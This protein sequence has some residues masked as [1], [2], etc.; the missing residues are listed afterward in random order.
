MTLGEGVKDFA[1]QRPLRRMRVLVARYGE[2]VEE[3]VTLE[4]RF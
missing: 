4:K 3:R 1:M 2:F